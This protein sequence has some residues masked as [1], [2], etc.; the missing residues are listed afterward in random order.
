MSRQYQATEDLE[1]Y[2]MLD[3]GKVKRNADS[4][5]T[6]SGKYPSLKAVQEAVAVLK[7]LP[8]RKRVTTD[9]K[10]LG[11]GGRVGP[12]EKVYSDKLVDVLVPAT[13]AAS[14][15]AGD[16][17]WG[18]S[19]PTQMSRLNYQGASGGETE[20]KKASAGVS[21]AFAEPSMD[22]TYFAKPRDI[23]AIF[24]IKVEDLPRAVR[25]IMLSC[26]LEEIVGA[27]G[28]N[29]AI[30]YVRENPVLVIGKDSMMNLSKGRETVSLDV[31][32]R[33]WRRL[34]DHDTAYKLERSMTEAVRHIYQWAMHQDMRAIEPDPVESNLAKLKRR[35]LRTEAIIRARQT[36]QA[37]LS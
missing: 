23:S 21:D 16:H 33:Y 5:L 13:L 27:G 1:N 9:V 15:Q 22:S 35:S 29:T 28:A 12:E 3:I 26:P 10:F 7:T 25:K 36:V 34:V 2:V 30:K 24:H 17:S 31:L 18:I 11:K 14:I 6:Y 8:L 32:L 19:N 37:L 4:S 20:W